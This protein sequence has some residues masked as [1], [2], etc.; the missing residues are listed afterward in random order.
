[1]KKKT[2]AVVDLETTGTKMDGTNRIIQ[3]S[4]VFV[5]GYKIVN[6]FNTLVNPQCNVPSEIQHLTGIS[7]TD[8][9]KAPI[10]EDVAGTIYAL[11]QDTIFVAH[12]I[13][14]DYR[15]LNDE[16]ERVGYPR[17]DLS[18]IDTVQL[19]Q[20]LYPCMNSYRLQDL[21]QS[22]KIVHDHPHQADSDALVTAKLL[23]KLKQKIQKLPYTLVIQ[24][25]K[26][27]NV[28]LYE[29]GDLFNVIKRNKTIEKNYIKVGKITLHKQ[30]ETI[31]DKSNLNNSWQ[32]KWAE[33]FEKRPEQ[34]Q[35]IDD[36]YKELRGANKTAFFEAP[37]GIGKTLGYLLPCTL[38]SIHGQKFLISTTTN[39]LQN[40]LIEKEFPKLNNILSYKPNVVSIKG[41][42]HYIDLDKFAHTLDLVQNDYTK[43]VQMR[44]LVWLSE[45]KTGDL[46]ELQLTV[47]QLPL[48]DEI[49]HH[50]IKGLNPD[51][52]YYKYDFVQR[53]SQ[54]I[55]N[56]DFIVTNHA[57]LLKH[58][59]EFQKLNRV[60]II[61]EAQ[62]LVAT[63]L[64]NNNQILDL[65]EVKILADTLLVKMES[66]VSYSFNN[67]VKQ[68]LIT[69]A[70]YHKLLLH[71]RTIDHQVPV[72]R[73]D[74]YFNFIQKKNN[75]GIN[76]IPIKFK[77]L[78]GFF[79]SNV[80]I[81]KKIDNSIKFINKKNQ[82]L[83]QHFIELLDNNRLDNQSFSLFKSYFKLCNQLLDLLKN[84]NLLSVE[85]LEHNQDQSLIWLS[86]PV[87]QEGAHLRIHFGLF[88]ASDFLTNSVYKQFTKV[89]L[90]SGNHFSKQTYSYIS[91]Q[92]GLDLKTSHY[93]YKTSFDYQKNSKL[94]VIKDAPDVSYSA[95]EEYIKYLVHSIKQ[96]CHAQNKQT[97]VLFNSN[98]V[99]E[100][101]YNCLI[102]SSLNENWEILA[103]GITG[104]SEKVKKRFIND[105][106]FSQL[107]LATGTFWE[108]I[109]LPQKKLE[110]LVITRLPFQ[111]FQSSYNQIRYRKEEQ[112]GGNAF[113]DI[114][115]PEAVMRFTQGIGRLIR[116]QND[117][118]LAIL[119]DS[120]ILTRNYGQEFFKSLPNKMPVDKII[121]DNLE[122]TIQS[123][124]DK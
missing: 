114:S 26:M 32:K 61:D 60:L 20:I 75:L 43:M 79:K 22:L 122:S 120:R 31:E 12:N 44:I 8:L 19:S 48:F 87:N 107:L 59:S 70:E 78:F 6:K 113:N 81:W 105:S 93:V 104:S 37:T 73:D 4:C 36:V 28:L 16:L 65:D 108:G 2:F 110:T 5:E 11:L 46:D 9:R 109:D 18:G 50:G 89:F 80:N 77:R 66:R 85:E 91:Q 97:M 33:K 82:S 54:E 71:I 103:Q 124:F 92:L 72:I 67:L 23:I 63:T 116:T 53:R 14:F 88:E 76:E 34:N 95:K 115:L 98:E 58:A 90:F 29:T 39:A 123:F 69:E 64:Q 112:K 42:Q 51:S 119:L 62:Q 7:Q 24:L 17:L 45:T 15:F 94:V 96:I 52:M 1:M 38:Q 55:K 21:A 27:S 10:F 86:Y 56:A 49:V 74:L 30:D 3:F 101:V 111:A 25:S 68:N 13:Q 35:L 57:Y 41:S 102:D 40:Q 84:W 121:Q 100:K 83:Y 117:K 106:N 99:I 118:G 47:K